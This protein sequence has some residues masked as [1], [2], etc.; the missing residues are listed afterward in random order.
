MV[1]QKVVDMVQQKVMY[2]VQL[3][4]TVKVLALKNVL[5]MCEDKELVCAYIPDMT[6][7]CTNIF[8][9]LLRRILLHV[10]CLASVSSANILD[11][12]KNTSKSAHIIRCQTWL[13]H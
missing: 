6:H 1:Q 8:S 3:P 4:C 12:H 13:S 10:Q 11:Q 2:R 9:S 7:I 5:K